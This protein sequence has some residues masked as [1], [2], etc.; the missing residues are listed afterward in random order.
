MPNN[1]HEQTLGSRGAVP[2]ERAARKDQL[3]IAAVEE[4]RLAVQEIARPESVGDHVGARMVAERLVAHRF[5][6]LDPGYVNWEWDVSLARAP[7]SKVMTVCEVALVPGNGALLAPEWVPW[8]ER[9]RP[10]DVTR[11]DV[12]PYSAND[13]RL[14]AG[15]EQTD[16]DTADALGIEEIG[17]GRARVLS[18]EGIASAAE[19]WYA[20]ERGPL[21]QARGKA[22]CS[23]CGFLLRM[24]GSL[25]QMF[26]VCANE[27]AQDDGMVVSLDHSCGA[28]SE[29]D[30]TRRNA[31][32]P[33][34]RSRVD[35]FEIH[36][37]TDDE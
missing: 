19:R 26:G 14:I 13:S 28:H 21:P 23:T 18:P 27:W 9:L 37:C 34:T 30:E 11:E 29:T 31:Q 4:A 1:K 16:P 3:L 36:V 5:A 17:M 15:F 6:C 10:E 7:R 2:T 20:S 24:P 25:G 12:L 8:E 35:D 32:W 22:T 33:I